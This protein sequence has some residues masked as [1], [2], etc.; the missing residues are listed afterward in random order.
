[1]RRKPTQPRLQLLNRCLCR[2]RPQL[3]QRTPLHTCSLKHQLGLHAVAHVGDDLASSRKGYTLLLQQCTLPRKQHRMKTVLPICWPKV[4]DL[5]KANADQ[6]TAKLDSS[7]ELGPE[8]QHA[9]ASLEPSKHG[10]VTPDLLSAISHCPRE[11]CGVWLGSDEV[12]LLAKFR[13]HPVERR[14]S[15]CHERGHGAQRQRKHLAGRTETSDG[16]ERPRDNR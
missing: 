6:H 5:R 8:P 7:A 16:V 1:M 10:G 11:K 13:V 2:A 12:G 3:T 15:R 9:I 4:A 14:A